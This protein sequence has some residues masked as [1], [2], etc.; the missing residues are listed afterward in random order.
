MGTLRRNIPMIRIA[1]RAAMLLALWPACVAADEL[2]LTRADCRNLVVHEPAPGV[3]YRP[4]VD[5]HGKAVAPAD[6]G[7]SAAGAAQEITIQLERDML[8]GQGRGGVEA[9]AGLGTLTIRNGRAYLNGEPLHGWDQEVL[10][11]ACRK[12]GIR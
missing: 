7:G 6:L 2:R 5:V 3:A 8:R 4:G 12:L 1:Q 9:N 10:L 11:D